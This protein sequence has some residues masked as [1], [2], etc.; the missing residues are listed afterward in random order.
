MLEN[1]LERRT[2]HFAVRIIQFAGR[3]A[4]DRASEVTGYQLLRSGTAI[5]A[6][7]REARRA[8]SHSDFIH[9][10]GLVEKETNET[11]YWLEL[12]DEAGLGDKEELNSLLEESRELLSIFTASGKTA[13]ANQVKSKNKGGR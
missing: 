1:E 11:V 7:Y 10:I 6:N 13:K 3:L 12:I 4:K 2:K 8:E 5:G 9:K